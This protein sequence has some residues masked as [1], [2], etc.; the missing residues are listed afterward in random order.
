MI[1]TKIHLSDKLPLTCSRAGTCCHGNVVK[2]NPW[3]LFCLAREKQISQNEFR[4]LYTELGGTQL[5]FNAKGDWKGKPAC[6]QYVP[7][8]GCSVHKGRP[9]ACR[10]FPIG[11]QVQHNEVHYIYEGNEFPCLAECPEVLNLPLLSVGDYL[12]GQETEQFEKGQDEYLELMQ[13]LADMAFE[14]LL[15][16]EL[17]LKAGIDTISIW[18]EMGND[19]PEKLVAR[20]GQ[21]WINLLIIPIIHNSVD[22]ISFLTEHNQLLQNLIHEEFGNAASIQEYQNASVKIM[23][24][25]LHLA[26]GIGGDPS[27]LSEHWCSLAEELLKN[28][29]TN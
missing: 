3:E 1:T 14:F 21:E 12:K 10:L 5:L 26:R 4:E 20:L 6:S 28:Y 24:L 7:G 15:D 22:A 27:S 2:L 8:F 29:D 9:L 23:G 11:R 17:A 18:K 25:A 13:N 19:E 16:T